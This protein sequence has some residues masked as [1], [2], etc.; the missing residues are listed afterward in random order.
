[1]LL[2]AADAVIELLDSVFLSSPEVSSQSVS[3]LIYLKHFGCPVL[4]TASSTIARTCRGCGV[5][6]EQLA[7]CKTTQNP[8][9]KSPGAVDGA[10][11]PAT[12]EPVTYRP[13]GLVL[14]TF[15]CVPAAE[16][17]L[18]HRAQWLYRMVFTCPAEA[19]G[20]K[21]DFPSLS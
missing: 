6:T 20:S 4:L 3:S 10:L 12:A 5:C 7:K 21:P 8:G 2:P 11:E 9:P 18:L 1:M 16:I 19:Q 15:T 13:P 17:K 14:R